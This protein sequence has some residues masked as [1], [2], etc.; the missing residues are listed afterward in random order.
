MFNRVISDLIFP[1]ISL[2]EIFLSVSIFIILGFFLIFSILSLAILSLS[3]KSYSSYIKLFF[4][5]YYLS[6]SLRYCSHCL[7]N[8]GSF[9]Y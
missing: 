1:G 7:Y 5:L 3:F 2:E 9:L 8:A 4:S 6:R